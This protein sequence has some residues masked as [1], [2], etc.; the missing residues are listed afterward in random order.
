MTQ[1]IITPMFITG[2]SDNWN[3]YNLKWILKVCIGFC[4]Y[5]TQMLHFPM[6]LVY[7]CIYIRMHQICAHIPSPDAVWES[8]SLCFWSD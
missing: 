2:T 3:S 8:L 5:K 6:A 4:K 1:D 7:V